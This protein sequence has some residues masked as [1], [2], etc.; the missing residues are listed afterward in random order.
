[1]VYDYGWE[2][3]FPKSGLWSGEPAARLTGSPGAA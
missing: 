1:M 3:F 2:R